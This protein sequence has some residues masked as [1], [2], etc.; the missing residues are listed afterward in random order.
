MPNQLVVD[1]SRLQFGLT[2]AFHFI[3]VPLTI[4]LIILVA[5]MET[6]YRRTKDEMYREMAD[7]WGKLYAINFVLG[8]VTGIT[9]EFQ[10]GTNWSEYSKFM[11]DIF[12]IPLAIEALLAFFLE[13]TFFGIWFFGRERWPQLRALSAWMVALGTNLSALWI[14]TANGFMQHPV[15]YKIVEIDGRK[16]IH[17]ENFWEVFF[18]PN[19]WWMLVHTI[20]ASYIVGSFFVLGVS[21]Y[22]FLKGVSGRKRE[23]FERSFRLALTM[24]VLATLLT[25][26]TGHFQG[27]NVAR[28]QPATAAAFEGIW[29]GGKG[30]P[31]HLFSIPVPSQEKNILE[32]CPIPYL[33][34]LLYT[35]NPFG[36]V[37]GL[38]D[39]PA[40]DR[41]PVAVVTWTFRLM[42]GL[43]LYFLAVA[44]YAW[45]KYR[46][47][48][49]E[50]LERSPK[51]LKA[52]LYTIPLPYIAAWLG[53]GA[54]EFG[55]Q[56]WAVYGLMRTSEAV[57]P[58]SVGDV[59]FSLVGLTFFYG[60]L[61]VADIYLLSKFAKEGPH[62]EEAPGKG[63]SGRPV[64][65]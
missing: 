31:F 47:G 35:N 4:G 55:R 26:V 59:V 24:A 33:G 50:A 46:K 2:A 27:V 8:V 54:A 36:E 42:V 63:I 29:E 28:T 16:L 57:S 53:W 65:A 3:F 34:S 44:V 6:L 18:N 5:V 25:A 7:F 49:L 19:V 13:S 61:I 32:C 1:L 39:F 58:V 62:L 37:K 10:F 9:M 22:H 51:L 38:K 11:G 17:L 20:L 12:G 23:F 14:I 40:E 21:T 15:G 56:P 52:L 43:G 41:P 48:G 64:E 60:V 30:V 45:W